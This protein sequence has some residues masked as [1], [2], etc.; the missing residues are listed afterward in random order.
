MSS[1]YL[2]SNGKT[3]ATQPEFLG[4]NSLGRKTHEEIFPRQK[5]MLDTSTIVNILESSAFRWREIINHRYIIKKVY[6]SELIN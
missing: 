6:E 1:I 3:L 4:E 5:L 2:E